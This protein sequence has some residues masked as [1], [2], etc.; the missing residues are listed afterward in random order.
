MSDD[1]HLMG[2][3]DLNFQYIYMFL[4]ITANKNPLL[5]TV[6]PGFCMYTS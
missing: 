1:V 5:R 6:F 2:G 3:S 4:P